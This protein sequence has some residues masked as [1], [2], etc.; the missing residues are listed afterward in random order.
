M[1]HQNKNNNLGRN[2]SHRKALL[3]NLAI[4]LIKYKRIKTTFA[5]AKALKKFIEP[6]ITR[7]KKQDTHSMRIV[8]KKLNNKTAVLELFKKISK[9]NLKRKG[10]YTR[11]I[12]LGKR[13]GDFSEMAIMELV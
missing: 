5:K 4:S 2:K 11:I 6:I 13:L 9:H 12:K 7:G 1:R 10:G 3:T 8:F